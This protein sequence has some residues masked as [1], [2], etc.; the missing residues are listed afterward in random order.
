[1]AECTGP[2]VRMYGDLVLGRVEDDIN[3][4]TYVGNDPLDKTDPSGKC[5]WD[6]CIGEGIAVT[7][8]V[9]AAIYVGT[10][11]VTAWSVH[12]IATNTSTSTPVAPQVSSTTSLP[13]AAPESNSTSSP[14][15]SGVSNSTTMSA[16]KNR[17]APISGADGAHTTWKTDPATGQITR[18]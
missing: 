14:A 13:A 5:F 16:V 18:H 1:V 10:A 12:E 3:L 11:A 6:A 2:I 4:Y 8:L 15:D 7:A 9:D 17:L